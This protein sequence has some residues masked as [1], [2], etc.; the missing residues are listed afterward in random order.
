MLVYKFGGTSLGSPDRMHGVAEIIT[1]TEDRKITVLSAVSGTTNELVNISEL[2]SEGKTSEVVEKVALLRT[3]YQKFIESLFSSN[4]GKEQGRSI[5]N[6]SI[7]QIENLIDQPSYEKTDKLVVAQGE[8]MSTQLFTTYLSERKIPA[9]LINALDFMCLDDQFEPNLSLIEEKLSAILAKYPS[10]HLFVTQGY[11]CRNNS[12]GVDNLKRGGSD[13]TATLIGAAVQAKEVQIWTDIDGVHDSD[14]RIVENTLPIAQL[15][16]EEAGELA[17]FG[18]KILHPACIFPAQQKNVAIRIKNTLDPTARGTLIT[19]EKQPDNIKS[20]AVKDGITAIKIKST[21]MINAYGFL[22]KI[23]EVFEKY[24][25][26]IDMITTSE[27]AVSLSIDNPAN[28][29]TIIDELKPFGFI[30]IDK[31]Q[32]I[33]CIVGDFVAQKKGIVKAVFM[34]LEEIPVRM[35]SYGGSKNNISLLIDTSYKKEALQSLNRSL[36]KR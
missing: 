26:P 14:P 7:N 29:A 32:S 12:G 24:K 27:I 33:I 18:A 20:I 34:S 11:I 15:S 21:R 9:V 5:V 30:E 28:L 6:E 17:Y 19:S 8:L 31:D 13:Y 3:K 22:R 4:E 1:S 25:T 35:I 36:F 2:L 16:F 10:D 23:F